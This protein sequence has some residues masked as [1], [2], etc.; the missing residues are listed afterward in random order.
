MLALQLNVKRKRGSLKVLNCA[1]SVS[2]NGTC[3]CNAVRTTADHAHT[4]TGAANG[5]HLLG[6]LSIS[7]II[8][9]VSVFAIEHM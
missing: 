5:L 4:H 1:H 8:G 3:A 9:L 2:Y 7:A 6:L